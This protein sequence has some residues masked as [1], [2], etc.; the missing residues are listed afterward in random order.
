MDRGAW[1]AAVNGVAKSRT[2]LSDFIFRIEGTLE[3][4]CSDIF[5]GVE[6]QV[7]RGGVV[8]LKSLSWQLYISELIFYQWSISRTV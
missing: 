7:L 5:I 2:R 4:L 3:I 1:W 6:I 8:C